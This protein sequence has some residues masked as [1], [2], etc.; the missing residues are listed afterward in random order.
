MDPFAASL[1]SKAKIVGTWRQW[2]WKCEDITV[3]PFFSSGQTK[4]DHKACAKD[5]C[6]YP[7]EAIFN[8]EQIL[9]WRMKDKI[10]Q[11]KPKDVWPEPAKITLWASTSW[12]SPQAR[13]TSENSLTSL[14]ILKQNWQCG[15]QKLVGFFLLRSFLLLLG[16]LL[17]WLTFKS[18]T[19]FVLGAWKVADKLGTKILLIAPFNFGQ[20]WT[21]WLGWMEGSPV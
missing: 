21:G 14:I 18:W 11:L 4:Q 13:V 10:P 1:S 19:N 15:V 3:V 5:V 16:W 17:G 2:K 20:K 9:N 6:W 8:M 12:P 7:N